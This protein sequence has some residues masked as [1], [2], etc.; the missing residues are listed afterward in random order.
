MDYQGFL[1]WWALDKIN[2]K[3]IYLIKVEA[4][5]SIQSNKFYEMNEEANGT[6]TVSYGRV[7]R[8]STKRSYP[9]SK[10]NSKYN[11]KIRK[12]YKDITDLKMSNTNITS[13]SG[14]KAFDEFYKVFKEYTSIK[15]QGTYLVDT[16]TKTQL[17][18][19]QSLLNKI[20]N[21]KSVNS[22]NEKLQE[23]YMIIPR[24]MD[25]V[26]DHLITNLNERNTLVLKEQDALDS[27][28]SQ[29]VTKV[30][31]PLKE[32]G[33]KFKE[34][35]NAD[36]DKIIEMTDKTNTGYNAPTIHK[37]YSI[38]HPKEKLFHRYVSK[39]KNKKTEL[40][41]HG[42]RNPNVF[43]ILKSGLLIRPS[44]AT[45]ISGKA[46]GE[47]IYTSQN[48]R[49]SLNYTGH[50]EDSIFFLQ[51]THVGNSKIYNGWYR[52]GK[53]ISR[54]QM[55][56]EYFKKNGWDSLFV[57]AGDGLL[58]EEIIV[59]NSVQTVTKYLIWWK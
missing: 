22:I 46:Y 31:N 11:E 51:D 15:V 33:I 29:I 37:I 6:F 45:V 50:D 52:D 58:N 38:T 23:L 57:S 32:L 34:A 13:D 25:N 49:K 48:V 53:D 4:T 16:A 55:N 17:D 44:N 28:D 59:Y 3:K 39:S 26:R 10:W 20:S 12:G 43:S 19:A 35:T 9:M 24:K 2:M 54:S 18:K 47:G 56:A 7:G 1:F 14:N 27:M 36:Y 21:Y 41:Y 5:D 42:T 8:A 30:S 40:L